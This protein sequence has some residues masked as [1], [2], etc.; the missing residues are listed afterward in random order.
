V[1]ESTFDEILDIALVLCRRLRLDLRFR[2]H[3][4]YFNLAWGRHLGQRLIINLLELQVGPFPRALPRSLFGQLR[5]H[6]VS[7][8]ATFRR[9]AIAQSHV[10]RDTASL[11]LLGLRSSQ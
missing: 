5:K 2:A 4:L 11:F 8:A 10:V 6:R 3:L 7:A 1:P 9:A